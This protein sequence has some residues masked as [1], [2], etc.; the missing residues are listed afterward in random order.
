MRIFRICH[1]IPSAGWIPDKPPN[2]DRRLSPTRIC[3]FR[4]LV[5]QKTGIIV[6]QRT[7][8][9]WT[10]GEDECTATEFQQHFAAQSA[11]NIVTRLTNVIIR[12]RR[13]IW[14][15]FITAEGNCRTTAHIPQKTYVL[16]PVNSW[17]TYAP[18]RPHIAFY[19]SLR[20]IHCAQ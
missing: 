20:K 8:K 7:A 10:I 14:H 19:A 11:V 3:Q 6:K 17:A 18:D 16:I 15:F 2:N 4:D 9:I 5:L 1:E 12:H 13:F